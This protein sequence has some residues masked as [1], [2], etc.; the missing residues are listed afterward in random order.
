MFTKVQS[1]KMLTHT[2]TV[3]LLF[4][5]NCLN[6]FNHF[7][8]FG[9]KGFRINLRSKPFKK[10]VIWKGEKGQHEKSYRKRDWGSRCRWKW[11]GKWKKKWPIMT[12]NSVSLR[13]SENVPHMIIWLQLLVHLHK[14]MIS[15]ATFFIFSKFWFFWFLGK[16]G[17]GGGWGVG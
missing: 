8:G 10:Y 9:L 17:W 7:M 6:V 2:K 1:H 5:R 11:G 14:M 16:G 12:K 3:W 15:S 13:I 4:S